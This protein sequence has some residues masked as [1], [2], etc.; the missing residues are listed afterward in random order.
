MRKWEVDV[1]LFGW[2]LTTTMATA[3]TA[4]IIRGYDTNGD[5]VC[6]C[7][8]IYRQLFEETT[9][10]SAEEYG[11]KMIQCVPAY[12]VV[13]EDGDRISVGFPA[14][15]VAE[16]ASIRRQEAESRAKMN[17]YERNGAEKWDEYMAI[18]SAYLDCGLP[19][20]IEERLDLASFPNFLLQSLRDSAKV[21]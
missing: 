20:F 10:K 2:M 14:K 13:F 11:L 5:L 15:A 18:T 21:R 17:L 9:G 3:T 12:Q 7:C 19:N 4:T 8:L 1:D 16:D 6:S